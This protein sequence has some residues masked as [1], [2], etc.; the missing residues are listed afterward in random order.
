MKIFFMGSRYVERLLRERSEVGMVET[1][2]EADYYV[3]AIADDMSTTA[4]KELPYIFPE[5][6]RLH[7]E[8]MI[9]CPFE[10][11]RALKGRV[12]EWRTCLLEEGGHVCEDFE[13]L[14]FFFEIME[15]DEE[16]E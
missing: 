15:D 9:L 4:I 6:V 12:E 1:P 16:E 7:P 5:T 13:D 2:E 11:P 14:D 3:I 8:N 10:V